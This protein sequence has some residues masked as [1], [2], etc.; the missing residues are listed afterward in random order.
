M[1]E[2]FEMG[3]NPRK[4][5]RTWLQNNFRYYSDKKDDAALVE[6]SLNKHAIFKGADQV[7][8]FTKER[9]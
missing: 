2:P 8:T 6:V 9:S 7:L 3:Y 4:N 1:I 5:F